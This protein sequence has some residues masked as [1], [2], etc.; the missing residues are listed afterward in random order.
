M[1]TWPKYAHTMA[2]SA[3]LQRKTIKALAMGD[4]GAS[5]ISIA[6][7]RN[8]RSS[9]RMRTDQAAGGHAGGGFGRGSPGA[10]ADVWRRFHREGAGEMTVASFTAGSFIDRSTHAAARLHAP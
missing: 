8:S 4:G 6:A 7:G 2:A 3:R 5:K 1:S 9:V 10:P